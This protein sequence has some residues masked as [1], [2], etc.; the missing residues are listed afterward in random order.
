MTLRAGPRVQFVTSHQSIWLETVVSI[1]DVR[2]T[3]SAT[4]PDEGA[5]GALC[6]AEPSLDGAYAFVVFPSGYEIA[7]YGL[8]DHTVL[9][10]R[11]TGSEGLA[12]AGKPV[13][14]GAECTGSG[15]TA[16]PVTLTMTVDG[17]VVLH[18]VDENEP[19]TD[20]SVGFF[21]E[22]HGATKAATIA[23]DE[24]AISEPARARP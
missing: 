21:G 5:V 17:E 24:I 15:T 16:D 4:F 12:A 18:L 3:V 14:L 20:G 13:S 9:A 11:N 22:I 23:F 2:V 1:G 7:R 19:L 10:S 6:R 8:E